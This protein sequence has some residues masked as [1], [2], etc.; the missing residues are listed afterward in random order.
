[1]REVL[2]DVTRE[3]FPQSAVHVARSGLEVLGVLPRRLSAP[4]AAVLHRGVAE[5]N[6]AECLRRGPIPRPS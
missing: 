4:C 5:Q 2:A 6:G 3:S 1:M